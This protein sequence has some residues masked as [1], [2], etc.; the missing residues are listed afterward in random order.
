MMGQ[1]IR[2]L[3]K[4][5]CYGFVLVRSLRQLRLDGSLVQHRPDL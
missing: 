2:K 4:K 1:V 5:S 3:F